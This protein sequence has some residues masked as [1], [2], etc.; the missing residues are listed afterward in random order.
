MSAASEPVKASS[1]L[2]ER[3]L[4]IGVSVFWCPYCRKEW[5]RGGHKEG[6][7]KSGASNH[8]ALCYE[9]VLFR[10][11][12]S[13][14]T[15]PLSAGGAA[16][17]SRPSWCRAASPRECDHPHGCTAC[18]PKRHTTAS[19]PTTVKEIAS[20]IK[21]FEHHWING[22]PQRL[23]TVRSAEVKEGVLHV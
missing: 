14:A 6:F 10:P 20:A 4:Q 18:L 13:G 21:A 12:T 17:M 11:E 19:K 7:V 1:L 22:V 9:I 2:R 8:V 16:I 15:R 3:H 5:R 23:G